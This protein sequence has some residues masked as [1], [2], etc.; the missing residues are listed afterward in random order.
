MNRHVLLAVAALVLASCASPPGEVPADGSIPLAGAAAE[1]CFTPG[2][3]CTAWVV[4]RIGRAQREILVMGYHFSEKRIVDALVAAQHRGVRVQI[5]LDHSNER[6]R[7]S[8]LPLVRS[9]GITTYVDHSVA[10]AH[11]KVMVFDR[12][13]V[14][15]GSFNWTAAANERNAENLLLVRDSPALAAEYAAYWQRRADRAAGP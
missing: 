6:V 12:T 15:T 2:G 7:W 10:I 11:N 4:E 9:A 3:D 8:G 14:L 5:V 1:T 13:S